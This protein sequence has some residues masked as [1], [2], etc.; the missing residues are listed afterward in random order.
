MTN[1]NSLFRAARSYPGEWS[2]NDVQEMLE[3]LAGP[4]CQIDWEP[5]DEEWGRVVDTCGD[6][7]A[8]VCARAP[9]CIGLESVEAARP[10]TAVSWLTVP[11]MSEPIYEVDRRILEEM[12]GRPLSVSVDFSKISIDDLWWATVS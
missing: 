6:V 7:R 12:F 9:I 3:V 4:G 1:L 5:G 11:S 8:L 2:R 10:G